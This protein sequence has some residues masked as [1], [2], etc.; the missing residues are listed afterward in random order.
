MTA[1]CS[2]KDSWKSVSAEKEKKEKRKTRHKIYH[3]VRYGPGK[4]EEKGKEEASPS[5]LPLTLVPQGRGEKGK[6]KGRKEGKEERSLFG[7]I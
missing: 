6:K 5:P 1:E 4:K 7:T 2:G 3:V